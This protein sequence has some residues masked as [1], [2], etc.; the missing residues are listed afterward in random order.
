MKYTENEYLD[1]DAFQGDE[2]DVSMKTVKLVKARKNHRCFTFPG[3]TPHDIQKGDT[4][5]Y[6]KALIDSDYWG[7]YR[8]CLHCCDRWLDEL[9]GVEDD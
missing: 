2:T 7:E 1:Y 5:R 6:E 9:N 8:M 4:Y 3:E